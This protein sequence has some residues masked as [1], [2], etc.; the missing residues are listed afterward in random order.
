MSPENVERILDVD[1][2]LARCLG[3]TD[4]AIRVLE[5]FQE[6]CDQDLAELERAMVAEDTKMVGTLA[7]RLK[8]ASANVSATGMHSLASKIEQAVHQGT[9]EEILADL[10]NL[11]EEWQLFTSTAPSLIAASKS[12]C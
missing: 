4:F 3:N 5:K 9:P 1:D 8:G 11:R 10:N 7:H 6:R 2:L 12:S